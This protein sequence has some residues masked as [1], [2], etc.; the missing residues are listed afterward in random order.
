MNTRKSF[1]QSVLNL[2]S[3]AQFKQHGTRNWMT[4]ASIEIPQKENG[5]AF[6]RDQRV[7]LT[8]STGYTLHLLWHHTVDRKISAQP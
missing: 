6:G 8:T 4:L 7:K 3:G 5:V 1:D 2:K